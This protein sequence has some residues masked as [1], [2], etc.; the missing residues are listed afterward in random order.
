M[1]KPRGRKLDFALA[2]ISAIRH[3]HHI[4]YPMTLREIADLTQEISGSRSGC[5]W[6]NIWRIENI[7]FHKIRRAIDERTRGEGN[8]EFQKWREKRT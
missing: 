4:H 7:A 1:S 3:K 5:T 6:Q 2:M 8:G